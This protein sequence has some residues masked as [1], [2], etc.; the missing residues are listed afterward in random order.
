MDGFRSLVKQV[1][2]KRAPRS[3]SRNLSIVSW[4]LRK[5]MFLGLG[6]SLR[7]QYSVTALSHL[8]WCK[9]L[10]A[11]LDFP[12]H[13]SYTKRGER[14]WCA[15]DYSPVTAY[16]IAAYSLQKASEMK[17]PCESILLWLSV[18]QLVRWHCTVCPDWIGESGISKPAKKKTNPT[19]QVWVPTSSRGQ[20]LSIIP[21]SVS[22]VQVKGI[23]GHGMGVP[24]SVIHINEA[25]CSWRYHL[26]GGS[27]HAFGFV[28]SPVTSVMFPH[29]EFH[30]QAAEFWPWCYWIC[31]RWILQWCERTWSVCAG[32]AFEKEEDFFY[33]LAFYLK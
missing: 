31:P 28:L 8:L 12:Q 29:C 24:L 4:F 14:V 21:G 2:L 25:V 5:R 11:S 18:F 9:R 23:R 13:C 17:L 33:L 19:T 3:A 15:S 16:A 22:S 1:N 26:A 20:H 32:M 10:F 30:E 27:V 6:R 7:F